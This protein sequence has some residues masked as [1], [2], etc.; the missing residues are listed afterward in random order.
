MALFTRRSSSSAA[1]PIRSRRRLRPPR[2][3]HLV[4]RADPAHARRDVGRLAARRHQAGLEEPWGSKMSKG[5]VSHAVAD[6]DR[7][8]PL[9]LH[10]RELDPPPCR[11]GPWSRRARLRGR[12]CGAGRGGRPGCRRSGRRRRRWRTGRRGRLVDQALAALGLARSEAAPSDRRAQGARSRPGSPGPGTGSSRPPGGRRCPGPCTV[13]HTRGPAAAAGGNSAA[14]WSWRWSIGVPGSSTS[15]GTWWRGGHQGGQVLGGRRSRQAPSAVA[16][17][18]GAPWW[19][20]RRRR[21]AERGP[22][23]S[24]RPAGGSS[25]PPAT[26]RRGRRPRPGTSR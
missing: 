13:W 24:A 21:W 16:Q 20:R 1:R 7:S 8:E 17:A 4:G 14:T 10:P 3:T 19:R 11:P 25:P 5:H 26:R 18:P 22:D 12:P 23:E 6:L 9:A 15:T 2:G